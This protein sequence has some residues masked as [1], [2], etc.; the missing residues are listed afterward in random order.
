MIPLV[1]P[2][3][4]LSPFVPPFSFY[5]TFEGLGEA[6]ETFFHIMST[7]GVGQ[8]LFYEVNNTLYFGERSMVKLLSN[9]N[10]IILNEAEVGGLHKKVKFHKL[11]T[12][13]RLPK[14]DNAGLE[15]DIQ[16]IL[17]HG[18][19]NATGETDFYRFDGKA[20]D[21]VSAEFNR[22]D[23]YLMVPPVDLTMMPLLVL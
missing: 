8:P 21:V 19:I 4:V 1:L 23:V 3:L 11:P 2:A 6:D 17:V 7:R 10:G 9:E 12:D 13:I 15:L 14:G 20:G 18:R 16:E 5:P 22:F